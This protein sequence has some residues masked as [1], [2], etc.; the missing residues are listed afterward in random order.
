MCPTVQTHTSHCMQEDQAFSKP[1]LFDSL[2]PMTSRLFRGRVDDLLFFEY[3]SHIVFCKLNF[4]VLFPF[5]T[6]FCLLLLYLD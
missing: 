6:I 5:I 1:V 4:I 2:Y 3:L